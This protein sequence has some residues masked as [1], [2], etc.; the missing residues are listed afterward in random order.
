MS[1]ETRKGTE[2]VQKTVLVVEDEDA[3]HALFRQI[4]SAQGYRVLS[5]RT[6]VEA[7]EAIEKESVDAMLLD[8][9][10]PDMHGLEV[11][12]RLRADGR[13]IPTLLCTAMVKAGEAFEARTYGVHD[14]LVKPVDLDDLRTKVREVLQSQD[15]APCPREKTS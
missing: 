8:V 14:I 5:A 11:L 6:G 15:P 13:S 3:S 7:L 9:R 2:M 4:L 10:M 12:D 1:V